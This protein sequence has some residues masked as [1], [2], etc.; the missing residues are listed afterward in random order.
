MIVFCLLASHENVLG[1][2]PFC[3]R[4]CIVV[5]VIGV[6]LIWNYSTGSCRHRDQISLEANE[7]FSFF[8]LKDALEVDLVFADGHL[9]QAQAR[10]SKHAKEPEQ[11][12]T[13][14]E[15][16]S[17]SVRLQGSRVQYRRG[18]AAGEGLKVDDA[19][20]LDFLAP[21]PTNASADE[22]LYR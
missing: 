17:P 7:I 22:R 4:D 15:V 16:P 14:I 10:K 5:S 13:Q 6:I 20:V 2:L 11:G 21:P 18:I 8:S 12:I 9:R 3:C 19:D 1:V